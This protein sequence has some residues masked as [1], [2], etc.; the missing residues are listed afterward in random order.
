MTSKL[1]KQTVITNIFPDIL[2]SKGNQTMKFGRLIK[3]KF[4]L[5]R[6]TQNVMQKLIPNNVLKNQNWAYIPGFMVLSFIKF[7][8]VW[9]YQNILK[10]NLL[11]PHKVK[12]RRRKLKLKLV[13]L[14]QFSHYFYRKIFFTLYSINDQISL[15]DCH[16]FLWYLVIFG[17][18]GYMIIVVVCFPGSTSWIL[19]FALAFSSMTGKCQCKNLN[20]KNEKSF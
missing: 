9:K 18:L 20:I 10:L 7:R 6:H 1:G 4:F 3:D 15:S 19:K 5:K 8:K 17:I 2:L 13:S 14:P 16:Y 11:L 12:K